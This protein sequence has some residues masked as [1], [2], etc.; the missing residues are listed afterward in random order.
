MLIMYAHIKYVFTKCLYSYLAHGYRSTFLQHRERISA[1]LLVFIF[2]IVYTELAF[3]YVNLLTKLFSD[4]YLYLHF[5]IVCRKTER[6]NKEWNY[7]ATI[8]VICDRN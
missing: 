3:K 7:S 1:Y 5:G 6:I 4:K 8:C 2:V